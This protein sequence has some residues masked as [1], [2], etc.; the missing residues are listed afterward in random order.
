MYA[1]TLANVAPITALI[2]LLRA[3]AAARARPAR[4]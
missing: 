3:E 4:A 2:E 1:R